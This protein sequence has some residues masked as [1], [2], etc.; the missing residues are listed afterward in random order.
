M[1]APLRIFYIALAVAFGVGLAV[2]G[3]IGVWDLLRAESTG[4]PDAPPPFSLS[5]YLYTPVIG[6]IVLVSAVAAVKHRWEALAPMCWF[7]FGGAVLEAL[8]LIWVLVGHGVVPDSVDGAFALVWAVFP[9][10]GLLL[11][12][13]AQSREQ[14]PADAPPST[15]MQERIRLRNTLIGVVAVSYLWRAFVVTF[16]PGMTFAIAFLRGMIDL[17]GPEQVVLSGVM[18]FGMAIVLLTCVVV[19]SRVSERI[20][21]AALAFTAGFAFEGFL[22]TLDY[23][24]WLG[25]P[26]EF[27]FSLQDAVVFIGCCA[28]FALSIYRERMP[29]RMTVV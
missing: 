8:F 28:A 24:F 4:G 5:S 9:L 23:A 2:A 7:L 13:K 1:L 21:H 12:A 26:R 10:F 20:M 17:Y 16:N 14:Q 3:V 18:S 11:A 22:D 25:S 19:S 29:S 27:T 15:S 6:A